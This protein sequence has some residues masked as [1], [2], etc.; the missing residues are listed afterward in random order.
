G[1][2]ERLSGSIQWVE[3]SGG[4]LDNKGTVGGT[5]PLR[6]RPNPHDYDGRNI[7]A[8]LLLDEGSDRQW[9][10]TLEQNETDSTTEVLDLA[11]RQDFSDDFGFPYIIE[12]SAVSGDDRSRRRR[13]SLDF[14]AREPGWAEHVSLKI[15]HQSALTEQETFEERATIV[16]GQPSPVARFRRAEFEQDILGAEA[17]A[18]WLFRTGQ[19]DHDLVAG[20]EVYRTQTEQLRTGFERDLS[21]GTTSTTVGPDDFPVRDFPNS[22]TLEAGVYLEDRIA[23]GRRLKLIPG[24][25]FD[26]YDLDP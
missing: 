23:F 24:I 15:Y 20:L 8:K 13:I 21:D 26:Y 22:T 11:R 25:R 10:L 2:G 6:T 17:T 14:D 4:E 18:R 16:Y 9:R 12:T 19:L 7:L 3:R 1:R 5:G